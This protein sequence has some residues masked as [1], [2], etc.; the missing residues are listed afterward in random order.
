MSRLAQFYIGTVIATGAACVLCSMAAWNWRDPV[1]F[2]F[3]LGLALL[4]SGLKV[5]LPGVDGTMSVSYV[6]VLLSMID[7][8]FPKTMVVACLAAATQSLWHT[9]RK[10]P[11]HVAFNLASVAIAVTVGY[12][13]YHLLADRLSMLFS[14]AV[15]AI[16]YFLS[17]TISIAA[18]TACPARSARPIRS[19]ASGKT[20]SKR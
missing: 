1:H 20:A 11:L 14:V 3:N 4:A 12:V 17:N 7:F 2:L 6:F 5:T 10:N 15:S 19:M 18:V 13:I 9:K 8:G 16:G